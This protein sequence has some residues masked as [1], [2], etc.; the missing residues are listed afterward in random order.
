MAAWAS[1][2]WPR[3]GC[4]AKGPRAGALEGAPSCVRPGVR[5]GAGAIRAITSSP[6]SR[7]S[8]GDRCK[9]APAVR[10]AARGAGAW[11]RSG[12]ALAPALPEPRVE[13]DDPLKGRAKKPSR[14]WRSRLPAAL[15]A[16]VSGLR[17]GVAWAACSGEGELAGVP[18]PI[19]GMAH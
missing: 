17:D 7:V 1:G 19:L 4:G 6:R 11:S 2:V 9:S 13:D 8:A 3:P 5:A 10:G 14:P 16:P 15:P 18:L 12:D